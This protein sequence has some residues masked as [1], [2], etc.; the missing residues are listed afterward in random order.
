MMNRVHIPY[1]L[2][3][4]ALLLTCL[5]PDLWGQKI[6]YAYDA[7][8]NRILRKVISLRGDDT[9]EGGRSK[10]AVTDVGMPDEAMA[11][12]YEDR[13]G[14]RKVLIYPNPTQGWLRIEFQEYGELRGARMLL[15]DIQGRLL[16]QINHVEPSNI[17]DLSQYPAGMYILQMIEGAGKNEWKIVKE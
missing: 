11:V 1:R 17:L 7:A 2:A 12:S 6:E 9:A 15:Y 13:L 8:G 10:S 3:C 16:R 14:E 4:F 5:T